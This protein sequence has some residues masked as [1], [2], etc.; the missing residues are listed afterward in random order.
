MAD[1]LFLRKQVPLYS[2]MMLYTGFNYV[3]TEKIVDLG[4]LQINKEK[5]PPYPMVT[6]QWGSADHSALW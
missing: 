3:T 2:T 5:N 4:S 6:Y 1:N